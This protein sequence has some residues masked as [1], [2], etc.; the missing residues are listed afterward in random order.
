MTAA[1]MK[2]LSQ[3]Q[4]WAR[5]ID[6]VLWIDRHSTSDRYLRHIDVP[7]VDTKFI[8]NHRT[9]LAELLDRQLASERVDRTQPPKRFAERYGFR[10]S[11][12]TCGC[13]RSALRYRPHSG[14][15]ARLPSGWTNWPP[16]RWM[17]GEC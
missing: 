14:L 3:D 9:M 15:S 16:S 10:T 17:P 5:L 12:R 6:V 11:R 13:A 7:G 2:V 4:N 1:P 8:E